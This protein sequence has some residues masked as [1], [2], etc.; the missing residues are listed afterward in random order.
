MLVLKHLQRLGWEITVVTITGA[1]GAASDEVWHG[2]RIIRHTPQSLRWRATQ[3][4]ARIRETDH[5]GPIHK[6]FAKLTLP[7]AVAVSF[8]DTYTAATGELVELAQQLHQHQ[9]YDLVL[10]LYHPLTSHRVASQFS[11]KNEVPWVAMTKDFYSWP[12]SLLSGSRWHPANSLKR[13]LERRAL[14][15][16]VSL[17]TISDYMT[18]YLQRV[19]PTVPVCTLPHCFDPDLYPRGSQTTAVDNVFRLVSVG[20]SLRKHD[21]DGLSRLFTALGELH[22]E[23]RI[24]PERFRCCFV[25]SGGAF[26]KSVSKMHGCEAYIDLIAPKQHAEAMAAMAEATCLLYLQT[27]FGTRRRFSEYV[28]ARRPILALPEFAG[29]MSDT[30]LKAY[31]PGRVAADHDQLKTTI[32]DLLNQFSQNGRL[33]IPYEPADVDAHSACRRAEEMSALLQQHLPRLRPAT[34]P[35]VASQG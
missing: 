17:V 21:S 3:L 22:R 18:E 13:H 10:S 6:I 33:D 20:R 2:I 15:K 28:G 29:T 24:T 35:C 27:P 14:R 34:D 8:P 26:V 1:K 12:D 7:A 16:A 32:C 4:L 9:A 30:F 23:G 11:Q 5:S 31:G 25:G 19:L